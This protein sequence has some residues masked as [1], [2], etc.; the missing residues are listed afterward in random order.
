MNIY[1]EI[2]TASACI[3][4]DLQT[5]IEETDEEKKAFLLERINGHNRNC[6]QLAKTLAEHMKSV[7]ETLKL[8][9]PVDMADSSRSYMEGLA[10]AKERQKNPLQGR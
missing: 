4:M 8:V 1:E 6:M 7:Y 2:V 10:D 9:Y 5:Y 3:G